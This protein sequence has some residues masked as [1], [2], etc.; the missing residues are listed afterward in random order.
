MKSRLNITIDEALMEQAKQFASKNNTS[1]SQLVERY[2]K[3]LVRPQKT[4]NIIQ[5]IEQ[6]PPATLNK[7]KDL[8]KDFYEDQ[9]GKYGF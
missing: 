8:K 6:L 5:L 9:K 4:K 1:V 3:G 2:F 7:S